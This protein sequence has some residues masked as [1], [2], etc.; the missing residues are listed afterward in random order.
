MT[1]FGGTEFSFLRRALS[2]EGCRLRALS[3]LR[4]AVFH[5]LLGPRV[6]SGPI[7]VLLISRL[8][9]LWSWSI[10]DPDSVA[11]PFLTALHFPGQQVGPDPASELPASSPPPERGRN[12]HSSLFLLTQLCAQ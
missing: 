10:E 8:P 1:N 6:S 4:R 2:G 12:G 7:R 3:S 9:G 11:P 5:H